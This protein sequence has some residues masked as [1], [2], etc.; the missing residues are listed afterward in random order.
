[1]KFTNVF[2]I[3]ILASIS[4]SAQENT[5]NKILDNTK[6]VLDIINS[7]KNMKAESAGPS[8]D[9]NRI[10]SQNAIGRFVILNST[11]RRVTVT[12]TIMSETTVFSKKFVLSTG[13]KEVFKNLPIGTYEY[14]AIFEDGV[15]AKNGEFEISTE[16]YSVEKEI[17]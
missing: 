14:K 13:D 8:S 9:P 4:C 15:I 2:L 16:N 3:I 11:A 7:T 6:G 1:M 5:L 10:G 17:K 12:V